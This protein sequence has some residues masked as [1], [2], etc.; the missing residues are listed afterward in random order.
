MPPQN[1]SIEKPEPAEGRARMSEK[2]GFVGLGIMGKP[3]ARNLMEAGYDLII[4]NRS[5]GKV[6]DLVS[7][8]A[9]AAWS[10]KEVA[11]GG[12]IV[13]T[14]L[15]GP[16]EVREVVAGEDGLLQGA[17][18]GSLLV[19]MSTSS[20]VLARITAASFGCGIA[21]SAISLRHQAPCQRMPSIWGQL[22]ELKVERLKQRSQ[23]LRNKP[24]QTQK[25]KQEKIYVVGDEVVRFFVG[26]E[27]AHT[28][29]PLPCEVHSALAHEAPHM[30]AAANSSPASWAA[31][32]PAP[33]GG[34]VCLLR[35]GLPAPVPPGTR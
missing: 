22:L 19:D 9:E 18:E 33:H 15:P 31:P 6:E 27:N 32:G 13:F 8:A 14:M 28:S 16:P 11:E 1:T 7:E 24:G 4:Y 30:V 35:T 12:G 26:C 17:G 20:P 2:V 25:L 3:M 10:P 5:R 23:S 21:L 34:P 29:D